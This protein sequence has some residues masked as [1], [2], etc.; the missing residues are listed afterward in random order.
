MKPQTRNSLVALLLGFGF[1][2][3]GLV[4]ILFWLVPSLATEVGGFGIAWQWPQALVIPLFLLATGAAA[5]WGLRRLVLR[6]VG[7]SLILGGLSLV[8]LMVWLR[9]CTSMKP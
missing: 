4:V 1:F 5:F 7:V 8:G 9:Q 6:A 3:L 2:F